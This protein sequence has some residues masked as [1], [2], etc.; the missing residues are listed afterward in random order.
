MRLMRVKQP[1]NQSM[2]T[3]RPS[4]V[5]VVA[6]AQRKMAASTC[7]WGI[8][9]E[10]MT[11]CQVKVSSRPPSSL[12]EEQSRIGFDDATARAR[13]GRRP[14]NRLSARCIRRLPRAVPCPHAGASS[15]GPFSAEQGY[16]RTVGKR[17]QSITQ[18]NH[19]AIIRFIS[20]MKT[21]HVL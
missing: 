20:Y 21:L 8:G 4:A 9:I 16:S 10:P 18:D 19:G 12:G 17:H 5:V 2:F 13:K 11:S 14:N 1:S 6:P 15:S 3:T 7:G